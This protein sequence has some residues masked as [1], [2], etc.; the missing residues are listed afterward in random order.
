MGTPLLTA[1]QN[2]FPPNG[3]IQF[4]WTLA[5]AGRDTFAGLT[6]L[7]AQ[8]ITMVAVFGTSR[9]LGFARAPS[10]FAALIFATSRRLHSRPRQRKTT[11]W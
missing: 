7:A 11:C 10:A 8:L 3:E 4:L 6:Q 9:R 5:L 1:L 2:T